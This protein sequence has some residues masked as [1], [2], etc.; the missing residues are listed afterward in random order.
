MGYYLVRYGEIGLKS[1]PVRRRFEDSL[2]GNIED[3]FLRN[4]AECVVSKDRG[5]IYVDSPSGNA[6]ELLSLVFGITSFSPVEVTKAEMEAMSGTVAGIS[7]KLLK[8]GD[9]FAIRARR[10]GNHKFTSQDAAVVLGKAVE[11]ANRG[12]GIRVDLDEPV[13]EISVE[14]RDNR[15]YV[16]TE[17]F[18]GPGGLPLGTQGRVLAL[19]DDELSAVSAWLMMKRGC[20]IVPVLAGGSEKTGGLVKVLERWA[21]LKP[22]KLEGAGRVDTKAVE[23]AIDMAKKKKAL[24][25]VTGATEPLGK[26]EFPV[27]YPVIGLSDEEVSKL[28]DTIGLQ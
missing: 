28:R 15:A 24:A 21:R 3:I 19:L 18:A 23:K 22:V 16:S 20:K 1:K 26:W 17:R 6:V 2:M 5:H 9:T 14:I 10:T 4:D 12:R 13:H 7:G 27:F 25:L 11:D 8:D